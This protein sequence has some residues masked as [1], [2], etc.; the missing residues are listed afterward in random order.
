MMTLVFVLA[1]FGMLTLGT[2]VLMAIESVHTDISFGTAASASLATVCT[3]G[4]GIDAVSATKNYAWFSDASKLFLCLL[5][6]IGRLE[7]FVILVLFQ[8]RF[9]RHQ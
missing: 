5:M 9:W 7:V 3:V 8:P 6:L 2:V 1:M 4:P